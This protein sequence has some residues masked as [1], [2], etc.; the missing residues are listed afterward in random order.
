MDEKRDGDMNRQV[1]IQVAETSSGYTE[2]F[3]QL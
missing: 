2:K 1:A 3:F